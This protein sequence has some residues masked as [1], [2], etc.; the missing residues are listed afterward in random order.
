MIISEYYQ[1]NLIIK[2]LGV[3]GLPDRPKALGI[4][5]FK[6]LFKFISLCF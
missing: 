3:F 1:I 2:A 4:I 6:K 5:G